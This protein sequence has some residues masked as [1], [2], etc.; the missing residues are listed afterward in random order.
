M[1]EKLKVQQ[2]AYWCIRITHAVPDRI[3]TVSN[4]FALLSVM[5]YIATM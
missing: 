5:Q 4:K 3:A 1:V 2:L